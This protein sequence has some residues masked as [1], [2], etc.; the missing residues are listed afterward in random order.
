MLTSYL[1]VQITFAKNVDFIFYSGV[2]FL[3]KETAVVLWIHVFG[4]SLE[5]IFYITANGYTTD[6]TEL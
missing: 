2:V 3:A 5:F 6:F 4:I 1:S